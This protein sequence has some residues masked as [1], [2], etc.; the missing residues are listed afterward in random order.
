MKLRN[1]LCNGIVDMK[2]SQQHNMITTDSEQKDSIDDINKDM[3]KKVVVNQHD[4]VPK[5]KT[6]ITPKI[7][8]YWLVIAIRKYN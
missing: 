1:N 5:S 8:S 4:D 7:Y 2:S 3:N 6:S